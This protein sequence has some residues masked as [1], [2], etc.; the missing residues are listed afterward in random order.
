M[1]RITLTISGAVV[2][3]CLAGASPPQGKAGQQPSQATQPQ[4]RAADAATAPKADDPERLYAAC[5]QGEANRNSDLC[6]QWYAADS[7]YEAAT[8][9]RRTGWFT[10]LGLIIGA[11]TM[12][13]AICAALFAKEAADHTKTSADHAATM[14][15]EAIKS[16]AAVEGAN[17]LARMLTAHQ[18][19]AYVAVEAN[20]GVILEVGKAIRVNLILKNHGNTP[21]LNH[22]VFS[23]L[24]I[25]EAEWDEVEP[26]PPE[27]K[28]P[29]GILFPSQ[30]FQ[31]WSQ[32]MPETHR[33]TRDNIDVVKLHGACIFVRGCVLYDDVFGDS[34]TTNFAFE[35]DAEGLSI[36][37]FRLS[38][39][40]NTAT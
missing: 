27:G 33:A 29:S 40:G 37:T 23:R 39:S 9:G 31:L 28:R 1:G 16:T 34:H 3:L 15:G 21:A 20:A 18:T 14:A 25:R 10:G 2:A 13:A 12:G 24:I 32:C 26:S 4:Q 36:N 17:D 22:A 11:V 38:E 30:T 19:R 35:M 8:W 6:A 5:S 7:A